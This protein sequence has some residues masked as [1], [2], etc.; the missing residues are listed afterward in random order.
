MSKST[1][2]LVNLQQ[3]SYFDSREEMDFVVKQFNKELSKSYYRTLNMLKQY[4]C[5]IVGICHLKIETIANTLKINVRT[6]RRHIKYLKENGFITVIPTSRPKKG[7]DGANAYAINSP[8]MREEVKKNKNVS[9]E[10][11][12]RTN[13]KNKPKNLQTPMFNRVLVQKETI[14]SLKLYNSF[15]VTKKSSYESQNR[16]ENI[17]EYR[18]CPEGVPEHIYLENKPF[19]SDGQISKLYESILDK[20]VSYKFNKNYDDLIIREGFKTL[21]RQLKKYYHNK[22][23]KIEN[24]FRY[25]KGAIVGIS[26]KYKEIQ[27][28]MEAS[29]DAVYSNNPMCHDTNVLPSREMTP[30]WLKSEEKPTYASEVIKTNF[31]NELSSHIEQQYKN[32]IPEYLYNDLQKTWLQ[33]EWYW[34]NDDIKSLLEDKEAFLEAQKQFAQNRVK[35]KQY[36]MS[37]DQ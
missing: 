24:I 28:T 4:S 33:E 9:A 20:L 17:K 3:Y 22:R 2:E 15:K 8:L 10:M 27:S 18:E 16:I 12:S 5:K 21:V 29:E 35:F 19:F 23:G 1:Y 13:E 7:G 34:S 11:S 6:V 36:L 32:H 31:L 14:F 25:I 26:E 30:E 37:E